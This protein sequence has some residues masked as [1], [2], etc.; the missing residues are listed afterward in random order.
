MLEAERDVV[1]E[2]S[3]FEDGCETTIL[4]ELF[5]SDCADA[6]TDP[7]AHTNIVKRKIKLFLIGLLSFLL[8]ILQDCREICRASEPI[9]PLCRW[10]PSAKQLVGKYIDAL[11][12][13]RVAMRLR[14]RGVSIGPHD[15]RAVTETSVARAPLALSR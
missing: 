9:Q 7:S 12:V 4:D 14:S 1:S 5:S 11:K 13:I 8:L 2:M 3:V 10:C 6:A 15:K